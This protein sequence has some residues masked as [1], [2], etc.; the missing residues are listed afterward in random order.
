MLKQK[1]AAVVLHRKGLDWTGLDWTG[2]DWTGLDWTDLFAD[3]LAYP[4]P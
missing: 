4:M 2:L 1:I 3:L